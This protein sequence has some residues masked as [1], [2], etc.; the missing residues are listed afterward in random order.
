M[1]EFHKPA[2]SFHEVRQHSTLQSRSLLILFCERFCCNVC[3]EQ[4]RPA[5][6]QDYRCTARVKQP[7]AWTLGQSP[8]EF[9]QHYQR[10][11]HRTAVFVCLALAHGGHLLAS[12]RDGLGRLVHVTAPYTTYE[13]VLMSDPAAWAVAG[14]GRSQITSSQPLVEARMPTAK[15]P[16]TPRPPATLLGGSDGTGTTVTAG[17][18]ESGTGPGPCPGQSG[19]WP[20]IPSPSP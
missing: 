16:S 12:R 17:G 14:R 3:Q 15:P 2:R 7:W 18:R 19:S 20:L 10:L 8:Q 9:T 13:P 11:M 4:L 1:N 5:L 6:A